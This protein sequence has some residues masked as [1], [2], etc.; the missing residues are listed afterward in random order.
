MIDTSK[1][2]RIEVIDHTRRIEDGG[3]RVFVYRTDIPE[4][5]NISLALQDG[6]RTLKIFIEEK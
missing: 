6:G 1:V 3:G 4:H 2:N 5:R